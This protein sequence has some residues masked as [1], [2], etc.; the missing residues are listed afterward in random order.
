MGDLIQNHF[1]LHSVTTALTCHNIV[2]NTQEK[3]TQELMGRQSIL[4]LTEMLCYSLLI[5]KVGYNH[6]QKTW[7]TFAFLGRFPVHTGP[8]LPLTPQ[9]ML[10]ACI[11]NFSECQL[12]IGWGKGGGGRREL[13]AGKR[14]MTEKYE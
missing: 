3:T 9:T 11:Q 14:E 2:N 13:K 12:C 7:D 4:P 10:D 5:L 1:V 8:T 6:G